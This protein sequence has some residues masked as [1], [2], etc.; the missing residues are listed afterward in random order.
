MNED[1][2]PAPPVP[3]FE[4]RS[5]DGLRVKVVGRADLDDLDEVLSVDDRV[6][7][8]AEYRVVGVRHYVDE[9]NGD[10]IREASIKPIRMDLHPWD[11]A[12]PTDKGIVRALPGS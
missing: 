10:L 9:K 7:M 1:Y 11:E 4:G 5:V 8:L 12:D 3:N 2:T 6:L